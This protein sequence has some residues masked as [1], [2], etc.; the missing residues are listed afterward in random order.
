MAVFGLVGSK[1][2]HSFSPQYFS[3]KFQR[4]GLEHNYLRFELTQVA[5]VKALPERFPG[6]RGFNVTLPYKQAIVPL[7]DALGPRAQKTN[8]VNTV[9]I[10][11]SG[12]WVG[13]N[14]DVPAFKR[15]LEVWMGDTVWR[16]ALIL[17]TGGAAQAVT[18]ALQ[19]LPQPPRMLK[20]SRVHQEGLAVAYEELDQTLLA[21]FPLIVNCT[22]LGMHPDTDGCPPLPFHLLGTGH[23]FYDLIYNPPLTRFLAQGQ[24]LGFPIHNGLKMLQTQADLAWELWSK[25]LAETDTN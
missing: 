13:Y 12:R 4:L 3:E 18:L 2:S 25:A 6:L 16:D 5:D 19:E 22:P 14:T 7:L 10:E 9:V 20:V 8:A 23:W 11:S 21:R 24:V 1:L 15:T 17:G